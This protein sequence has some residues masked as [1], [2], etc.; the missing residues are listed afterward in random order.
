M[1]YL[2]TLHVSN[3]TDSCLLQCNIHPQ[4]N[5]VLKL[6]PTIHFPHINSTLAIQ[7]F[8]SLFCSSCYD[9]SRYD[10]IHWL[11]LA[12]KVDAYPRGNLFTH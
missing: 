12:L 8:L 1:Q 2:L 10:V 3:N 11:K 4:E 9:A 6:M 7:I 5:V